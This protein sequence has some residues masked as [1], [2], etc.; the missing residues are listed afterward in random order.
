MKIVRFVLESCTFRF[1]DYTEV[2]NTYKRLEVLFSEIKDKLAGKVFLLIDTD[3]QFVEF[4]TQDGLET[5][6][7]CRRIINDEKKKQTELVK[8]QSALKAPN[9]DIEDTLNG[10]IFHQAL[11]WFK[12]RGE[13]IL[14]FIPEEEKPEIPSY[15]AMDLR[16]RERDKL[17]EFFNT[18]NGNNKVLFAKKYVELL[19][20]DNVIP[21]WIQKI[22][23]YFQN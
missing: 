18:N 19:Q 10:K 2:K 6:L 12:S 11:L 16:P 9:T 5:H 21:D 20:A 7:R 14:D 15:F 22:K 8:I 1:R 17:D 23:D 4:D 13:V 3:R